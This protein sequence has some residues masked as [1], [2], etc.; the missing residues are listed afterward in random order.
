MEK[1][2]RAFFV[3]EETIIEIRRN[4]IF[5]K[6]YC[7]GKL[8]HVLHFSETAVSFYPSSRKVF[9]NEIFHSDCW[10]RI[11]WL[12][13]TVFVCSEFS[14]YVETVTKINGSQFLKKN[15]ILTNENWFL[16]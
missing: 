1:D 11:F 10:K 7:Q 8:I 2:F 16:G 6:Y 13:E 12:V 9:F 4:S 3:L 15:H 5:W 14:L